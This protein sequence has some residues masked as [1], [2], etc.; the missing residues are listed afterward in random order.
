MTKEQNFSDYPCKM[1][2]K[3]NY[4]I[5]SL[6]PTGYWICTNCQNRISDVAMVKWKKSR[7]K[8]VKKDIKFKI[9]MKLIFGGGK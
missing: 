8:L 5:S 2:R 3:L 4:F 1:C 9:G 6:Y 7:K